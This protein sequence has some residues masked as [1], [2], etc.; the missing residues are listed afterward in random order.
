[1]R[2]PLSWPRRAGW[3]ALLLV[4]VAGCGG[5]RTKPELV[6]GRHGT[7]PGDVHRPRAVAIDAQDRVFL[8][9]FTARIQAY[10]RHGEFLGHSWQTPDYR[11]GRPS[12]ISIDQDGNLLVS[13]SHYHCIRIYSPEGQEL[14][15]I[16]SDKSDALGPFDYVADVV[17]DEDRNYY[18]AEFG[19]ERQR[20][21]KLGPDGKL[22]KVWGAQG[23]EPGQFSRIRAL[24]LGPDGNLY[25]ADACN[26]RIQVFDRDGKVVR[27]WGESGEAPGQLSYPYDLAFGRDGDTPVLYV[28]E[29]GNHRVQKFTPE[30]QSLGTWGGPG[31]GPGQFKGPWA[32]ALDGKGRVHAVDTENHR[33]QRINF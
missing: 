22:L 25:V 15:V 31:R 11:N 5:S 2:T 20:I 18:V 26:H 23:M 9:D 19:S 14:R 16:E 33:V 17:Q 4:A 27:V 7:R 12:G 13:D 28:M 29:Y 8:V 10:D 6:W 1:V 24:A 30:G 21:R 3:L 32:L